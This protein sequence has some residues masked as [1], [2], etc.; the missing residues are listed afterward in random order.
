MKLG[1]KFGAVVCLNHEDAEWQAASHVV[2][3][4]DG[5]SLVARIVDLQDSNP[6]AIIDRGELIQPAFACPGCAP[7]NFTSS[8]KRW[9]GCGFSYRCQRFAVRLMFLV[10]RQP[11]HAVPLENA[12]HGGARDL[13]AMEPV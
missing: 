5:R 7:E 8:C 6:R 3:E 2:D 1:L 13:D 12:V 9:P 10:R 4:L 11:I